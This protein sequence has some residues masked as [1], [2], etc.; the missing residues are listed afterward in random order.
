VGPELDPSEP[1]VSPDGSRLAFV[2]HGALFV[3]QSEIISSRLISNPAFFPDGA[4]LVFAEGLPGRRSIRAVWIADRSARTLVN[5]G[6]VFEPAVSPNGRFLAYTAAETGARQIWVRNL[7]NGT[8]RK[9]TEGA[10]N[11]GTPAWDPDSRS[12]VFSSDCGRGLGLPALYR[13]RL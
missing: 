9:L 3:Q 4:Q 10:C 6:D 7:A 13:Q 1:A 11:N 12:L 8:R 5:G 2:S